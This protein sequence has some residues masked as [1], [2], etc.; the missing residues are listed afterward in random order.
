MTILGQNTQGRLI[1]L[2]RP[3]PL[4]AASNAVRPIPRGVKVISIPKVSS[5]SAIQTLV[6]NSGIQNSG[7]TQNPGSGA[8]RLI[9]TNGGMVHTVPGRNLPVRTA[10][11]ITV[12]VTID[13]TQKRVIIHKTVQ[14]PHSPACQ[15]V[16][17]TGLKVISGSS[18]LTTPSV[19]TNQLLQR[20]VTASGLQPITMVQNQNRIPVS[21]VQRVI[22]TSGLKRTAS[23]PNGIE[24]YMTAG[25]LQSQPQS[26]VQNSALYK[27]V[28]AATS[29]ADSQLNN[30]GNVEIIQASTSGTALLTNNRAPKFTTPS[31]VLK[32]TLS[33]K[34]LSR[35]WSS[36][37]AKQRSL[38]PLVS[39]EN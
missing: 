11:S 7:T 13:G 12:P 30:S 18:Y 16:E 2:A 4:N 10:Q 6:K 19:T 14:A 24:E 34:D 29:R 38:S 25:K 5:A 3:S 36:E 23:V 28:S 22:S 20:V 33:S 17:S 9:S 39:L 15:T 31:S 37:D 1:H 32:A 27:L 8:F 35:L 26:A 21:C